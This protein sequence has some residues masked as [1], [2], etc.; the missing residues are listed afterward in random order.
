MSS[1]GGSRGGYSSSGGGRGGRG[2]GSDTGSGGGSF[3]GTGRGSGSGGGRGS[4]GSQSGSFRSLPSSSSSIQQSIQGVSYKTLETIQNIEDTT[5]AK[6]KPGSIGKECTLI[7]NYFPVKLPKWVVYQY[8]VKFQPEIDNS[9][10]AGYLMRQNEKLRKAEPWI[11]DGKALL[12]TKDPLTKKANEKI[13]FIVKAG[14]TK[15]GTSQQ[16]YT[17]TITFAINLTS[18]QLNRQSLQL[19][20]IL[21]RRAVSDHLGLTRIGRNY[22]DLKDGLMPIPEY[23]TNIATGLLGT[24]AL[25]MHGP[26]LNF[27]VIYKSIRT[28]TCLHLI[29]DAMKHYGNLYEKKIK[30]MLSNTIVMCGYGSNPTVHIDDVDFTKTPMDTFQYKGKKINFINYFNEK[31]N[32]KITDKNQPL[33]VNVNRRNNEINYFIPELCFLTGETEE[34]KADFHRQREIRK[35]SGLGPTARLKKISDLNNKSNNTDAFVKAL[36]GWNVEIESKPLELKGRVLPV[37]KILFGDKKEVTVSMPTAS[38]NVKDK[39]YK[40]ID[41]KEWLI[42][43]P[44]GSKATVDNFIDYLYKVASPIGIKIDKPKFLEVQNQ[45]QSLINGLKDTLKKNTNIK[46]VTVVLGRED[47]YN[48]VKLVCDE[49][50]V[51]SQCV[52]LRTINSDDERKIRSIALKICV[53]L[54]TKNGGAP[55]SIDI[56]WNGPTML[57]GLDVFHSG[58]IYRRTKA[59]VVGFVASTS[60]KLSS[61]FT[62]VV[63]QKT[64]GKEI[65]ETLDLCL[66]EALE[67]F[68]QLNKVYPKH[69]IF[70]RDGVGEG[71]QLDVLE[72]EYKR[73]KQIIDRK[74]LDCKICYMLVLKRINT[75]LFANGGTENPEA[76]TIVDQHITS[77][78]D[79]LEF[80]LISQHANQGSVKPT[81]YRCLINEAGFSSDYLQT[82]TY[83]LTHMYFNWFGTIKVPAPCMYAHKIAF[84]VGQSIQRETNPLLADKLFYL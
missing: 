50:A 14:G 80:F 27:D 75:R 83:K 43:F 55:W 70:Y 30:Q 40:P 53:Q 68:K 69:V 31:Y 66:D 82:T 51:L 5:V 29:R 10:L 16:Q 13:E 72:S 77:S 81:H 58:E 56:K 35:H 18:S 79:A 63:I 54:D 9:R 34:M 1:R 73:C 57:V 65:V 20:N 74:Q 60:S 24:I 6:G 3:S 23:K 76:G 17:V 84:L 4:G 28:D 47:Y 2:R 32:V 46:F 36:K 49:L 15:E 64:P 45:E 59:S 71:Q 37:E 42:V 21:Y 33:L 26:M 19:F 8:D 38:W 52:K 62:K 44:T 25:T 7:A 48:G 78:N 39:L 22:F 67:R 41:I 11:F 12:F 61:Y